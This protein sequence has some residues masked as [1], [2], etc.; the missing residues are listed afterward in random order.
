MGENEYPNT[1][2]YSS[3]VQGSISQLDNRERD[4]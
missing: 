1:P 4:Q 3:E 2:F